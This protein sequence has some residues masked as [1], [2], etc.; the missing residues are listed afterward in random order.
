MNTHML[1]RAR[2]LWASGDRRTDRHNQRAW[3]RS[4]RNLGRQWLLAQPDHEDYAMSIQ[5][6]DIQ[7]ADGTE[8][9][10]LRDRQCCDGLCVQGRC[11]PYRE[12]STTTPDLWPRPKASALVQATVKPVS[13]RGAVLL[14]VV[15]IALGLVAS[16]LWQVL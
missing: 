15:G 16:L 13:F 7:F 1:R 8:P 10:V 11:C 4:I 12:A 6:R 9:T 14:C 5:Y 2:A 3:V